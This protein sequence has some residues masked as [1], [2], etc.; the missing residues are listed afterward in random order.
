MDTRENRNG[1][2]GRVDARNLVG[3][4]DI[5]IGVGDI[6]MKDVRLMEDS[7]V[8]AGVGDVSFRGVLTNDGET[9]MTTDVGSIYIS[10]PKES[11]FKIDAESEIGSI[12]IDFELR[13]RDVES[14]VVGERVEGE[15]GNDASAEL[16]LKA[17]TGE[18]VVQSA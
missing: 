7:Q 2:V 10:L 14:R 4:L 13:Q 11:A 15:V 17:G 5:E 6:D 1:G 8:H 16:K 3:A 12:D 9:K 18:I